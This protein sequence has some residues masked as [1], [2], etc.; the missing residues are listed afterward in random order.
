MSEFNVESQID[1]ATAVQGVRNNKTLFYMFLVRFRNNTLVQ[2]INAVGKALEDDNMT[3]VKES[4]QAL[5]SH[6]G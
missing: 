2:M 1:V 4:C 6:C 5:K 3:K